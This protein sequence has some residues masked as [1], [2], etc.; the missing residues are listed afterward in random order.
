MFYR[1]QESPIGRLL[2]VGDEAG[3]RQLLMDVPTEPWVIGEQWV[4]AETQLDNVCRQLDEYFAG[5]R[6]RFDL[7][8]A[9]LGTAFQRSVWQAL[10]EIPFGQTWSYGQLA[11]HIGSPQAMRAVGAAN[12]A[13]PIAVIQPCH[14]VIGSNG[15]LT[16]FSGG[17][18]RKTLLLKLEGWQGMRQAALAL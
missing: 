11:R 8:L 9:P 13:N 3:L 15:S 5:R 18:E 1:Y 16:G 14:R 4:P 7:R 17:L 2:L 6:Q 12:G 10:L